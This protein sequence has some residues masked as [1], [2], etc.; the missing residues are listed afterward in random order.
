M[1]NSDEQA[2]LDESCIFGISYDMFGISKHGV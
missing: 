2:W 1:K